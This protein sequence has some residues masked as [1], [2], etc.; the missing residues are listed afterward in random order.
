MLNPQLEADNPA[1]KEIGETLRVQSDNCCCDTNAID[2]D[3]YRRIFR[4]VIR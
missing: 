1:A 4:L 3:F 2:A